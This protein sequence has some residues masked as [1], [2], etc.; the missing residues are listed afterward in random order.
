MNTLNRNQVQASDSDIVRVIEPL[1]SYISATNQPMATL[2]SALR[3]LASE[4]KK[5]N[6]AASAHVLTFTETCW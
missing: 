3:A 5:T 6:R 1:A 4:V 2:M